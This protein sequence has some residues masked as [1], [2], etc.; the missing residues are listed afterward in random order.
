MGNVA[1]ISSTHGDENDMPQ[2]YYED[3][4]M[5]AKHL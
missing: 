1:K 4:N 5:Y 3:E 2:V